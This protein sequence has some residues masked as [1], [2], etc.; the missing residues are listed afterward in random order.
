M[1]YVFP[2]IV[3]VSLFCMT[4]TVTAK[5]Q[6]ASQNT[7]FEKIKNT[8]GFASKEKTSKTPIRP[9]QETSTKEESQ[10]VTEKPQA[11]QEEKRAVV[12]AAQKQIAVRSMQEIIQDTTNRDDKAKFGI[13][14]M[15]KAF[16]EQA[17]NNNNP[18]KNVFI[19]DLPIGEE[20]LRTQGNDFKQITALAGKLS[21]DTQKLFRDAIEKRYSL[22]ARIGALKDFVNAR[23]LTAA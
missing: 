6:A 22:F 3:L 21:P 13:A 9:T 8:F 18:Q 19:Q 11:T 23:E 2:T 5:D 4:G 15:V 12:A 17:A 20:L 16:R 1:K 14:A 10:P 7:A